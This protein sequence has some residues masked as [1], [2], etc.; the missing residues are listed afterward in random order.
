[1]KIAMR[2]EEVFGVEL[3]DDDLQKDR[4]VS[5]CVTLIREQ[6]LAA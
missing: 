4:T 6:L 5:S 1:M 3:N 2:L